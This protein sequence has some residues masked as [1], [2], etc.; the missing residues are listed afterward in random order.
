[1][2]SKLSSQNAVLED[3]KR[4]MDF[5]EE[6]RK[7]LR[8]RH[9]V[10]SFLGGNQRI[11]KS[12]EFISELVEL[13]SSP[14]DTENNEVLR[15]LQT[16]GDVTLSENDEYRERAHLVLSSCIQYFISQGD[17]DVIVVLSEIV[18]RWVE[19]EEVMSPSLPVMVKRLEELLSWLIFKNH[20]SDASKIIIALKI[21]NGDGT[22]KSKTIKSIIG[23]TL[24]NLASKDTVEILTDG[25]LLANGQQGHFKEMLC[26][27]G[28]KAA[29]YQLNRLCHSFS[30]R[31]RLLLLDL[32]PLFTHEAVPALKD[33]LAKKPPWVVVRNIIYIVGSIGEA[34]YFP[35]VSQ[36][37][38]H[39]DERVQHEMISCVL[40][41]GTI[42][43]K[44]RLIDGLS[45]VGDRMKIYIIRLLEKDYGQDEEVFEALTRLAGLRYTFS[46]HSGVELL[47]A[48]VTALKSFP[49]V[50]S[51]D[52]L[53]AIDDD[54]KKIEGSED[55]ISA[56]REAL[57]V[58]E[59]LVRH[60]AQQTDEFEDD[61]SFDVD[62][63]LQQL[64]SDKIRSVE[65]K[66]RDLLAKQDVEQA[67][68]LILETAEQAAANKD[69]TVA[70]L[71]RDRLLEVNPMAMMEV[72][73]LGEMIEEEKSSSITSH[74]LSM[75]QELYDDMTTEEFNA[76]YYALKIENFDSGD[77]I[78]QSGE[79]DT[80]LYFLNSGFVSLNCLAGG[81][82]IFLKKMQP[83][84]ILGSEQFF[85]PSVWT[86]T[87]KALSEVQLH[88][89]S[90]AQW[91][92]VIDEYPRLEGCLLKYCSNYATIPQL[93]K[94][95]GDD[96]REFP[97]YAVNLIT[98]NTLLDPYGKKGRDFKGESIDVSESGL[99]FTIRI[100]NKKNAKLLLGRQIITAFVVDGMEVIK[101]TGVVVGVKMYDA[102]NHDYSVHVKLS[103]KIDKIAF[104][105]VLS[106]TL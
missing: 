93:L 94:M 34:R 15:L 85:S 14:F 31:E 37:F 57:K 38:N 17:K 36:Y 26:G 102:L 5:A 44:K 20:F 47:V 48:I 1:M 50:Q 7:R 30:K 35:L 84:D 92:E 105:Q 64:A 75:W 80:S 42:D 81:S 39:P 95:A 55:I 90:Y 53:C 56:I 10:G 61:V 18:C 24:D 100:S 66:V 46:V 62:P 25:Y 89:L 86:V 69:F 8:L 51:I 104:N 27:L 79:T 70:E 9:N 19:F 78:V 103:K 23:K 59:P 29:T 52:L 63:M 11:L 2:I 45:L 3:V 4:S 54:Y 97:R 83:S 32:I 22:Q 40:R 58:I 60:K 88:V 82:D 65:A 21:I 28:V 98:K 41:L 99:A 43:K 16:L 73:A 33:C 101:V 13:L 68:K 74:H 106:L 67:G 91:L 72:I 12:N 6:E 87:L 49:G 76:L 71:L 96:R 77:V